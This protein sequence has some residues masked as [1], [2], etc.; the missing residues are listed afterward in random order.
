MAFAREIL[1]SFIERIE[2]LEAQKKDVGEDIKEVYSEAKG[3]GFDS[4]ILR[5]VIK[6][7]KMPPDERQEQDA[8]VEMYLEALGE[9]T[10]MTA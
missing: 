7:R 10:S 9:T 2:N 5:A 8:L 1:R 3:S 6:L 4:K